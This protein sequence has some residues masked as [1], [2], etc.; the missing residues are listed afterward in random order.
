MCPSPS[1]LILSRR[2]T[3]A[4]GFA[5]VAPGALA[6]SVVDADA[7]YDTLLRRY[8][9]LGT[10]GVA[11]VDYGLWRATAADKAALEGY[12]ANLTAR[13]PS[14]MARPE[15]F[16]YWGNLYNAITLS[17]V[18]DRYPVAS[19]RDIK[20]DAWLDPRSYSGPWRQQRVTV[21]GRRL[22]LDDIEHEIMR[23]TFKD[24][25]V[26]YVVNCASFGCPNLMNRAWRAATLEADLEAAARAFVNHPRGVTVLPNGTLRVS[27]IYKWF[28]ADFGGDDAGLIAHF[29][30]F[31]EPALA[32]RLAGSPRIAEDDYDW[33]L[34]RGQPISRPRS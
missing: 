14:S 17:V 4:L 24:P 20:S 27:S 15:A 18:L 11:R 29:R 9:S 8:V 3:L 25:R 7:V 19:I 32:Q 30:Q 12:I 34:N 22:S 21:E 33:S 13:R 16:A 6:Q 1:D 23:P 10:D 5:A 26:H 31:A 2:A 28:I